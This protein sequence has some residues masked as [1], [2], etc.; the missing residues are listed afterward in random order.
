[1][2]SST[3]TIE[4][5]WQERSSRERLLAHVLIHHAQWACRIYQRESSVDV[6]LHS[7]DFHRLHDC[8]QRMVVHDPFTACDLQTDGF[9]GI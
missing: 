1:M 5:R 8:Q 4:I 9:L 2:R 3:K 7:I 6:S